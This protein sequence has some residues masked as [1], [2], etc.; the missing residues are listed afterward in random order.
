MLKTPIHIAIESKSNGQVIT[1]SSQGE[2]YQAEDQVIVR[3]RES[4][5]SMGNTMTTVKC[6]SG[7]IK[8]IRHG[9]VESDQTFEQ[10]KRI[11]GSYQT[12]QGRFAL[13]SQT[14]QISVALEQLPGSIHWNYDLYISEQI[15]GTYDIKLAIV[16]GKS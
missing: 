7:I 16:E 5:Q 13:E 15:V 3:Y 6:K 4:E 14:H 10:G 1:Q 2:L 9:D 8:V 12:G 11:A